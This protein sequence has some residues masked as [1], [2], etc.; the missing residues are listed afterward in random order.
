MGK[1]NWH[2]QVWPL[3]NGNGLFNWY[4]FP[5]VNELPMKHKMMNK[6]L[7]IMLKKL[8]AAYTFKTNSIND[9]VLKNWLKQGIQLW[10]KKSI[11]QNN[12]FQHVYR[13]WDQIF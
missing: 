5:M 12:S 3:A 2:G 11:D 7:P 4:L 8:K 6:T 1:Y 13:L 10:K 9:V